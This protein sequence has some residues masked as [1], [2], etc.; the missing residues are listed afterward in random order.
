MLDPFR[1]DTFQLTCSF[2][3][4]SRSLGS[5]L[6]SAYNDSYTIICKVGVGETECSV[7]ALPSENARIEDLRPGDEFELKLKVLGF[8][9]LYQRVLFG[10]LL[11]TPSSVEAELPVRPE[12]SVEPETETIAEEDKL[13]EVDSKPIVRRA[14]PLEEVA[15]TQLSLELDGVPPEPEPL[16]LA[17]EPV[18]AQDEPLEENLASAELS[19]SERKKMIQ[20]QR[21]QKR[22]NL[23][24]KRCGYMLALFFY[25]L[26]GLSCLVG[27]FSLFDPSEPVLMFLVFGPIFV[28]VGHLIWKSMRSEVFRTE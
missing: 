7:Q 1:E 23:C 25:G 16:E 21:S 3:S 8:D 12:D 10:Q 5:Q 22:F 17:Q 28:G 26:G 9:S 19:A 11:D 24:M 4:S 18:M 13:T 14:E 20:E 6:D 15:L 27:V 2:V